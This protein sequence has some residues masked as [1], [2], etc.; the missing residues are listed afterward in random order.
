MQRRTSVQCSMK[1]R[2]LHAGDDAMVHGSAL[3]GTTVENHV[4]VYREL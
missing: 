1:Y 3:H 2:Q 4:P